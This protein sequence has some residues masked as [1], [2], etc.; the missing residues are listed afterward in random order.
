MYKTLTLTGTA[1]WAKLNE[2]NKALKY[3]KK[4]E[5]EYTLDLYLDSEDDINELK[6]IISSTGAGLKVREDESDDGDFM[7]KHFVKFRRPYQVMNEDKELVKNTPVH[8]FKEG[9]KFDG[10]IGNGS[11][12]TCKV[13]T[14]PTGSGQAF[15]LEAVRIDDLVEYI[16][17]AEDFSAP[18]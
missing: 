12:V 18:F 17:E 15:R 14:F 6:E 8:I 16:Q 5:Y 13:Q 4:D 1:R 10:L 9:E 11:K 3:R 7:G 2:E